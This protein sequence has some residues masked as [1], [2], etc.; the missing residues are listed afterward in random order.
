M[1]IN[2]LYKCE[3]DDQMEFQRDDAEG[4][5][6]GYMAVIGKNVIEIFVLVV[7]REDLSGI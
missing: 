7:M 6:D 4:A 1:L 5:M 2:R 3:V